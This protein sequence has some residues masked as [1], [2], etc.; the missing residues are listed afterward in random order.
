[1]RRKKRR[2]R[3]GAQ[4]QP[5]AIDEIGKGIENP[6]E[7]PQEPIDNNNRGVEPAGAQDQ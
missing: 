3:D 6:G 5:A 4:D 7:I 2:Q 1:V